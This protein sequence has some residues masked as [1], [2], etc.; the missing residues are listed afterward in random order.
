MGKVKIEIYCYLTADIYTPSANYVCEGGVYCFH[1]HRPSICPSV[2]PSF[3]KSF[4]EMFVELSFTK[5]I[6]LVKTSRLVAI[7]TET[8]NFQKKKKILK[9]QLLRSYMGDKAETLQNCSKY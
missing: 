1:V 8:L 3:D 9:N 7:A 2:F 5:H 6:I 4:I